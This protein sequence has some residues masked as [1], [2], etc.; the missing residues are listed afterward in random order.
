M[1][2]LITAV[3]MPTFQKLL[4]A[5]GQPLI[6]FV[7]QRIQFQTKESDSIIQKLILQYLCN[8]VS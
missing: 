1:L 5:R 2:L 4:L 7:K 6:T 8:N 3:T